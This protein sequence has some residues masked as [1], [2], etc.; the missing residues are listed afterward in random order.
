VRDLNPLQ[1][2]VFLAVQYRCCHLGHIPS[3]FSFQPLPP[4]LRV[5]RNLLNKMQ[6]SGQHAH[7]IH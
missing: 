3:I 7:L 1:P 4:H 5:F 6:S 2:K